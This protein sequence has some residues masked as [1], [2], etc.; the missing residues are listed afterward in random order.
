MRL[1]LS[2]LQG[3]IAERSTTLSQTFFS[4]YSSD[5]WLKHW[6]FKNPSQMNCTSVLFYP[7]LI[8]NKQTN[9]CKCMQ[10]SF[11][12]PQAAAIFRRMKAMQTVCSDYIKVLI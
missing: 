4:Q 5:S 3:Q 7:F 10:S 11:I 9:P 6:N 2:G 12:V 1:E 8:K